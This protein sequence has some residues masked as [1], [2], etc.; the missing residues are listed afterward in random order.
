MIALQVEKL[1]PLP[2]KPDGLEYVR[3]SRHRIQEGPYEG[4]LRGTY[5]DPRGRLFHG[6]FDMASPHLEEDEIWV[7]AGEEVSR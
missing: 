4:W 3:G 6:Y 5:V 1:I 7:A 2:E